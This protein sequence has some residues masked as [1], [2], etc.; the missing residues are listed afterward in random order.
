MGKSIV[1]NLEITSQMV[2]VN[3]QRNSLGTYEYNNGDK[4]EGNW[5][6]GR[7]NGIGKVIQ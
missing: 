4:Y 2:K 5:R 7:K 3:D 6:D 1:E